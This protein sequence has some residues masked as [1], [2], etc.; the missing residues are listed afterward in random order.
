[1]QPIVT[2]HPTAPEYPIVTEQLTRRFGDFTAVDQASLRVE[3]RTIFGFLGP[4][5]SG[6]TTVIKMLCGLLPP[7]GGRAWVDGLDVEQDSEE[8][9]NRIGYMSQRFSLYDDLTVEENLEFYARIYGLPENGGSADGAYRAAYTQ[10]AGN[11]RRADLHP[12]S[13]FGC[14]ARQS[15]QFP[16][17][18]VGNDFAV[19]DVGNMAA[20]FR[21]IHVMRCDKKRHS[22]PAKVKQLI[23]QGAPCHRVD[24]CRRLIKKQDFRPVNQRTTERQPLLP[25]AGEFPRQPMTVESQ[26]LRLH[27]GLD[28]RRKF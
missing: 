23:P 3:P 26:L 13:P 27:H 10:G 11:L 9:R 19:V 14:D 5:G 7:S 15:L 4:N 1:M 16:R 28:A 18:P 17:C 8:V 22:L 21:L 24:A 2:E 6:K 25:A 12:V 20:A